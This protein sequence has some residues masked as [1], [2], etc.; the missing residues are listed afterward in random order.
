MTGNRL[1]NTPEGIADG[2]EALPWIHETYIAKKKPPRKSRKRK[3]QFS[4]SLTDEQV[5]E[6]ARTAKNADDFIMLWDGQWQED[7]G[8]QSEAD[9]AL[10][11]ALAF[12]TDKDG[13]Q[14]DRLFR[15]SKL[16][17]MKW[18][19]VHHADGATYGAETIRQ[20]IER[21][22][23]TYSPEG[24]PAIFERN[25]RYYRVKG[26]A[27]YPITNF[28]V[29]PLE[30]V[31]TDNEAQM[32]CILLTQ[33]G[34]TYRLTFMSAD[35]SNVQKFKSVLNKRTIA[36]CYTGGDG[37]LELFKGYLSELLWVKKTGIGYSG[38][39]QRENHWAFVAG[40]TALDNTG[41]EIPDLVQPEKFV[42]LE[43][44]LLS[45]E[46]IQASVM[47]S[48]GTPI[49]R[50]NASAKTVAVLAWCAG[51]FL[52]EH[53]RQ[54]HIKYPHLFLIGEAGSRQ[55]QYAG[56]YHPTDVCTYKGECVHPGHIV[57][58]HEGISIQQLYS[59][60]FG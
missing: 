8:S 49:L 34:E 22:E 43:T 38:F 36:L 44:E 52:K 21:T 23:N 60:G 45:S 48:L 20:A 33:L 27:V 26:D 7:F 50:Y 54:S 10:C 24:E 29:Q 12:W 39:L 58:A 18:D 3:P 59:P 19:T 32:T 46:P 17:R 13:V 40:E 1:A 6:K 28:I 5:L 41:T 57:Y 53:L 2:A 9:L 4:G 14:I 15:Q 51:C 25:G 56:T 35:F 47:Q 30:M 11:C 55:I 37:D 31:E 16:F 42:V